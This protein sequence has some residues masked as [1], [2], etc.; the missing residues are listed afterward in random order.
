MQS[1][2]NDFVIVWYDDIGYQYLTKDEVLRREAI[3]RAFRKLCFQNFKFVSAILI[4][5]IPQVVMAKTR[6]KETNLNNGN[7][8]DEVAYDSE[9]IERRREEWVKRSVT[10]Y[11]PVLKN[12]LKNRIPKASDDF[13]LTGFQRKFLVDEITKFA[14]RT[15]ANEFVAKEVYK[16]AERTKANEFVA[17][18]IYKFATKKEGI[19]KVPRCK[20][21]EEFIKIKTKTASENNIDG[22]KT[23]VFEKNESNNP[24]LKLCHRISAGFI[25]IKGGLDLEQI[26]NSAKISQTPIAGDSK[27]TKVM[28]VLIFIKQHKKTIALCIVLSFIVYNRQKIKAIIEEI[29]QMLFNTEE[30]AGKIL[31]EIEENARID[32]EIEALHKA[33]FRGPTEL[34][35]ESFFEDLIPLTQDIQDVLIKDIVVKEIVKDVVVAAK[36]LVIPICKNLTIF[37]GPSVPVT[38]QIPFLL[39]IRKVNTTLFK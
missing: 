27:V 3:S 33:G 36:P 38:I 5:F 26:H 24:I 31:Y 15:G 4:S 25:K 18:E 2:S 11:R 39:N 13:N 1:S 37:Y 14:E 16:F 10:D 8:Y 20:K 34:P 32:R 19:Q 6:N 30:W 12:S 35:P 21:F 7:S 17:K 9:A 23:I 29:L 22:F 28:K